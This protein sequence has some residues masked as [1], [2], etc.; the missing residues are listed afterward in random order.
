MKRTNREVMEVEKEKE[1][2]HQIA[3]EEEDDAKVVIFDG[4]RK[5]LLRHVK[6]LECKLEFARAGEAKGTKSCLCELEGKMSAAKE[7]AL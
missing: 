5:E 3:R 4:E 6:E 7:Q 2:V 1:Q